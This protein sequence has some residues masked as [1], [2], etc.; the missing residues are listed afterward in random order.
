MDAVGVGRAIVGACRSRA[1]VDED[2]VAFGEGV[3]G[4]ALEGD[5]ACV[6]GF[7]GEVLLAW[8]GGP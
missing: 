7:A 4:G 8:E 3:I 1:E 5:G 6:G 2:A